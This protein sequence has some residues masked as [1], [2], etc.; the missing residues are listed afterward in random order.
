[1]DDL[2]ARL[3]EKLKKIEALH[4]GATTDGE[5]DAAAN[6]ADAI[7]ARLKRVEATDPPIEFRFRFDS[8]YSRR[9]FLALARRYG[10]KPYRNKG[11]RYSSVNLMVSKGFCDQTLWPTYLAISDELT[12][13]LDAVTE[14]IVREAV[15][16]DQSEAPEQAGPRQLG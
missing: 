1:M 10:L 5:R 16:G 15:H 11:Q 6:V 8:P 9:V 13:H 4:A 14:R 3:F 7:R 2:E 12:K